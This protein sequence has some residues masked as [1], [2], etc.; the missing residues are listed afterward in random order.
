MTK[1]QL[2]F[3][4]YDIRIQELDK[5][6]AATK[7]QTFRSLISEA[8]VE[9]E[10][11]LGEFHKLSAA[12]AIY[13]NAYKIKNQ[14][15]IN[16]YKQWLDLC[17]EKITEFK[18]LE[19]T[20]ELRSVISNFYEKLLT[21]VMER[22]QLESDV[23]SLV[24]NIYPMCVKDFQK[25]LFDLIFKP[26]NLTFHYESVID[27]LKMIASKIIP[28]LE[29]YDTFKQLV[30]SIRKKDFTENGDKILLYL[31]QYKDATQQWKTLATAYISIVN[32]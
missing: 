11:C 10:M 7:S 1:S 20:T 21:E 22:F 16:E 17:N 31:E 30:P 29:E 18:T 19:L 15:R 28:G 25:V 6:L 26:N 24:F 14:K 27:I 23:N 13:L 5:L 2:D 12:T 4:Y 9:T 8:R 3:T 32:S